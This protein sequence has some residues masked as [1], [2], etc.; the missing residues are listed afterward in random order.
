MCPHPMRFSSAQALGTRPARVAATAFPDNSQPT[1]VGQKAPAREGRGEETPVEPVAALG[2]ISP[3]HRFWNR[4]GWWKALLVAAVY[5]GLYQLFGLIINTLFGHLVNTGNP[6]A[7]GVSVFIALAAPILV[8]GIV[9]VI[10]ASSIGWLKELF[11][12][13][14]IRGAWWMWIGVG[15]V[16]FFNILRFASVDYGGWNVG[17]IFSVLFAGLCIGFVE[18]L[19]TRGFAVNLLRRGGYGERSVMLLSSLIFAAMHA[20]NIFGGQNPL[21][22]IITVVYTFAF[23]ILMYTALRVTGNLIWPILLHASTDPGLI[24][25]TGAVDATSG[26]LHPGP[27]AGIAGLANYAVMLFAIVPLIF[28]RGRVDRQAAY[29]MTPSVPAPAA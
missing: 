24:L 22:V 11:A 1:T 2:Q 14:P 29:G 5:Y 8:I 10:F 19:V 4:G 21:V 9:L 18:E 6:F 15:I 16:L 28:V 7:D 12:R 23:G 17:A 13:Q 25:L 20:G 27:L 26:T 3:W